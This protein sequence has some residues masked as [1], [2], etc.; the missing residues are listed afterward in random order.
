MAW[1]IEC[2]GSFGLRRDGDPVALPSRKAQAMLGLL[3]VAR[4]RSLPRARVAA[5]LWE[6][7]DADGARVS[8]RQSLARIRKAAGPVVVAEGEMLR[9]ADEVATDADAFA[10]AL[11]RGH[12]AKAAQLYGGPFLDGQ[13]PPGDALGSAISAERARLE[14]LAAAVLG[15]ELSRL[16][17]G[18]EGDAAAHRLLALD[19]LSENAHRQ[20]IASDAARG[21]RGAARARFEA[22]SK[23]LRRDLD[24]EP[25]QETVAL[26]ARI[27]GARVAARTPERDTAEPIDARSEALILLALEADAE[28]DSELFRDLAVAAGGRPVELGPGE[29]AARWDGA[30]LRAVA[31]TALDI[32]EALEASASIALVAEA[33]GPARAVGRARRAAAQGAPGTV[34]I[35]ADLAPRLGLTADGA[36]PVPLTRGHGAA[37]PRIPFVGR[38]LERA[39]IDGAL[40]AARAAGTGLAVHLCGEAGIGKTR[41][42]QDVVA[43]EMAR[44]ARVV[45]VRFAP[46]RQGARHIAQ[47]IMAALPADAADPPPEATDRALLAWLREPVVSVETELRL[48]ALDETVR[49]TRLLDLLAA[50]MARAAGAHGL[51]V[52]VE[53]VHWAPTGIGAFLLDLCDRLAARSVALILTERPH[54]GDLGRRLAAR[55]RI[56]CVRLALG[57]LAADEASRLASEAAPGRAVA[58]ALLEHAGG[59]PLFLLRLVESGW[60]SGPLPRSIGDLVLEQIEGLAP[61]DRAALRNAAILGHGF[62]VKEATSVFPQ[63][64]TPRPVGDLLHATDTGLAFGHD[65]VRQA[66]YESIPEETRRAAHARAAAHH[67]GADPVR[68]VHHALLSDDA[69]EACRAAT[70]A[71]NAMI[72]Q[73]RLNAAAGFIEAGLAVDGAAEDVAELH[74]CRA[75]VRRTRGDLHGALED[76]RAAHS[77]AITDATRVAMR[78]RE[79]LVLHRL[80]RGDEADRALDAAEAMADRVGLAGVGRAEVYEQRGNRAFVNGDAAACLDYH[81][82]A[83]AAAEAAADPKG[84]AR[85]HGGLGDAYVL[86]GRLRT[87]YDHFERAVAGAADAGLGLVHQEFDFMR[88]FT[89][90]FADPGPRAHLLADLAVESALEAGAE[91]AEMLARNVRAELRL[92]ALDL[93]GARADIDR[94]AALIAADCEP[95]FVADIAMMRGW[96]NLREGDLA[97]AYALLEPHFGDARASF[98]NGAPF[99]GLGALCAPNADRRDVLLRAAD[100]RISAGSMASAEIGYHCFALE[101]MAMTDDASRARGHLER[102]RSMTATEPLGLVDFALQASEVRWGRRP[103][104][105]PARAK[106]RLKLH[107]SR[108]GGLERLFE[109]RGASGVN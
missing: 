57:P 8:L 30:P 84:I 62:E 105:G 22:F 59:H 35:A 47:D 24:A 13:L 49:R 56:G 19:P 5:T 46:L 9:L 4:Q 33:D 95:R 28:L 54:G 23:A 50:A 107:Q 86:S 25:E 71:A 15:R 98:Y 14:A 61:P 32:S 18:R 52:V 16:A 72:S 26:M 109:E 40:R 38:A 60:H 1:W 64:P 89:L 106:L 21:A 11:A 91:R 101:V 29:A 37:R 63:D 39:Q 36:G 7:S 67:R 12:D 103:D 69:A 108:V 77:V 79:A 82:R 10:A 99:L 31:A 48:S 94:V 104:A 3:A 81:R 87:A 41:L 20:L 88:A 102:L 74:S 17:G 53:D 42:T 70:A 73:L 100:D 65:L 83:L 96:I 6:R 51:L 78:T 27:R 92:T 85:A 66:I 90:F 76:Y 80:G 93:D 68:W 75:G 43:S 2:L 34:R 58:P 97:A 45:Q 44:G 55:A